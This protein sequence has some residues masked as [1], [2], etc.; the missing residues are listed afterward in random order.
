MAAGKVLCSRGMDLAH[1]LE[2]K[3]Y[4]WILKEYNAN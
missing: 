4:D 2:Q 1:E 3:G